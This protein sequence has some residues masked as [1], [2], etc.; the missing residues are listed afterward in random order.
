MQIGIIILKSG[1]PQ[2][3]LESSYDCDLGEITFLQHSQDSKKRQE[4]KGCGNTNT[5]GNT[6]TFEKKRVSISSSSVTLETRTRLIFECPT[7][8]SH[9]KF[10]FFRFLN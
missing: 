9:S 5:C 6:Y 7:R 8:H 1:G 2:S 3:N 10:D 4:L